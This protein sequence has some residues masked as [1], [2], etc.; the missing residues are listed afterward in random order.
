M[1][2][3]YRI[4]VALVLT[5][6]AAFALNTPGG[7]QESELPAA[8]SGTDSPQHNPTS[9]KSAVAASDLPVDVT[10]HYYLIDVR[11]RNAFARRHIPGAVNVRLS[12]VAR[13]PRRLPVDKTTPILI[14]GD[15][16][17]DAAGAVAA[18]HR[19]GFSGVRYIAGGLAAWE[20]AG[21]M[22]A[23]FIELEY[24]VVRH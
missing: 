11:D 3:S 7:V 2:S 12:N 10:G 17:E 23:S 9:S 1:S 13:Q 8:H 18:L 15:S 6:A 4:S 16:E 24:A 21:R 5:V 19:L 22:T 14:Y 20:D